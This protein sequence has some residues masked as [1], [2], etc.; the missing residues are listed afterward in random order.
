MW[1]KLDLHVHTPASNCF[2]HPDERKIVASDI[3]QA[4]LESGLDGIAVTDHM[5]GEWIDSVKVAARENGKLLIFP[6]VELSIDYYHVIALFPL[7]KTTKDIEMLLG[8]LKLETKDYGKA[9]PPIKKV[10]PEQ[11]FEAIHRRG[12]LVVLA[13]IDC[14]HTGALEGSA[15]GSS[16][17]DLFNNYSYDAVEVQGD[18]PPKVTTD[19]KIAKGMGYKRLPA[20]Y[21]ASDN[22]H[23]DDP[24]KHSASGIGTRFTWFSGEEDFTL[25]SLRQC[26]N[27]PDQRISNTIES[28]AE[29]HPAIAEMAITG[30][31]LDGVSV[32]FHTG[33]T[34]IV[35]GKGVG[36]SL[37]I[38]FLRLALG[39]VSTIDAIAKDHRSK[40]VSQLGEDS[41]L[42]IELVGHAGTRYR[43]SLRVI[44]AAK[45]KKSAEYEVDTEVMNLTTGE[46]IE[47]SPTGI[48]PIRAFSQ[49]E[50]IEISREKSEQLIQ[51]DNFVDLEEV[52]KCLNQ[53]VGLLQDVVRQLIDSRDAQ[54]DVKATQ[55]KCLAFQEQI[56]NI[57]SS[58][59]A[60]V[61]SKYEAHE[62]AGELVD[63]SR[64]RWEHLKAPLINAKILLRETTPP[65]AECDLDAARACLD[66]VL[67]AQSDATQ[68]ALVLLDDAVTLM[69]AA[70]EGTKD[71]VAEW[72]NIVNV[73]RKEY[74][75]Y[76]EEAGG[77]SKALD[78]KRNK[79]QSLLKKAK[80]E[81]TSAI[82][83]AD[84]W[85]TA[86]ESA[87][88]LAKRVDLH[89]HS[90]FEARRDRAAELTA[91]SGELLRLTVEE[92][93][94]R[95]LELQ[96]LK[97][98]QSK[99]HTATLET[100]TEHIAPQWLVL[101]LLNP[102]LEHECGI[103]DEQFEMLRE[104]LLSMDTVQHRISKLVE[105]LPNDTP[106]IEYRRSEGDY[107]LIEEIS[108]GKRCIALI[109][110][111]LLEGTEPIIID[112]PED[113]LDVRAIW[114]DVVQNVRRKKLHRQFIFTTH[115][116]T[117]AVAGDSDCIT[118]LEPEGAKTHKSH[119]GSIDVNEIKASA[120]DHLEGGSEAFL[121]RRRKYNI[122]D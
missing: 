25:E 51:L 122:A 12:G 39:D 89:L 117:I 101:R 30:G 94:S 62:K 38:E 99:L 19:A 114:D 107:A 60:P 42:R 96:T 22:P 74:K 111:A 66:K 31:F 3:V 115:N 82:K 5:T 17:I 76:I 50:I 48:L 75:L 91:Q 84:Q 86:W 77:T 98:I 67:Q 71:S 118:V 119:E 61:F 54:S 44:S 120:I 73:V 85:D 79:L 28:P 8:E 1:V 13:H 83:L 6:G 64:K 36:K 46:V 10:A 100:L 88:Q 102:A 92:G 15:K 87:V 23:P 105:A 20:W 81:L 52:E 78:R 56:K 110:L 108:Q 63:D 70:E 104:K 33:L 34:S 29:A 9:A 40:I 90:R 93:T 80:M 59:K 53:Y 65:P 69:E 95:D 57:D 47:V 2:R 121:L 35:G 109:A 24:T 21:R 72:K 116:S 49:G 4:A 106:I 112:Q 32:R 68:D 16:K 41:E 7:E 58:L 103:S 37:I 26:F 55:E 43:I 97:E 27:D 45:S 18:T 11:V 113:S 14:E